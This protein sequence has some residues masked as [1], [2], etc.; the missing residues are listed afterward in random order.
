MALKHWIQWKERGGWFTET[1]GKWKQD[2]IGLP[3]QIAVWICA[4]K[5]GI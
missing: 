1:T 2:N 5:D 4:Y 3:S